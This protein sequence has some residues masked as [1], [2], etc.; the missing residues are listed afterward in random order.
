MNN[1][2]GV[3]RVKGTT[4]GVLMVCQYT[5]INNSRS[6][7]QGDHPLDNNTAILLAEFIVV[8]IIFG[9]AF[10]LLRPLRQPKIIIQIVVSLFLYITH[11]HIKSFPMF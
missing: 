9:F 2:E 8:F 3:T 4:L 11:V 5:N 1:S 6:L 10:I 7:W